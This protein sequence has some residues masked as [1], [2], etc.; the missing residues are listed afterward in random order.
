MVS[1]D[2]SLEVFVGGAEV[3]VT[4]LLLLETALGVP[5]PDGLPLDALEVGLEG[6]LEVGLEV[7]LLPPDEVGVPLG[8]PLSLE[9]DASPLGSPGSVAVASF[10]A[11]WYAARVSLPPGLFRGLIQDRKMENGEGKITR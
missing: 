7:G 2:P 9:G 1:A 5:L 10:D 4:L 8:V 6:G 3:V 11:C